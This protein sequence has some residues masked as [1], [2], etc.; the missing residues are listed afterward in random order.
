MLQNL[1]V[2][3]PFS[4]SS[5]TALRSRHTLITQSCLSQQ[6]RGVSLKY[7]AP[8]RGIALLWELCG[9]VC[10]HAVLPQSTAVVSAVSQ[11]TEL[12]LNLWQQG[13]TCRKILFESFLNNKKKHLFLI[14]QTC[15][16]SRCSPSAEVDT[17]TMVGY[18]HGFILLWREAAAN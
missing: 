8:R 1:F 16:F 14:P 13:K 5:A 7:L 6:Q 15:R 17:A 4:S 11:G 18:R 9:F 12:S 10:N 2:F 3:C